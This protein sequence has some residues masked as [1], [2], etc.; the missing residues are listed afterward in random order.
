MYSPIEACKIL[1]GIGSY[2]SGKSFPTYICEIEPDKLNEALK[3]AKDVV[4]EIPVEFRFFKGDEVNLSGRVY[5]TPSGRVELDI[6]GWA[7]VPPLPAKKIRE[8]NRKY[9]L[10]RFPD[11]LVGNC[12]IN[13]HIGYT[14]FCTIR[15]SEVRKPVQLNEIA[16]TIEEI[17]NQIQ[18]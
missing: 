3:V 17:K 18:G 16:K 13:N 9:L 8:I 2:R 7:E 4:T 11:N 14:L 10:T 12:G 5:I 6:D 15:A 1:G